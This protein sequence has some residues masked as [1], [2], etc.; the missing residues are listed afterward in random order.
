[1]GLNANMRIRELLRVAGYARVSTDKEEQLTSYAAQLD[2]YMKKIA[3]NP[4]WELVEVYADEGLSGTSLKKRDNFNR[5]I[6]DALA[7]KID[8]III[9]AVITKG[10]FFK[11]SKHRS[12]HLIF[13]LRLT[14][15]LSAD[16]FCP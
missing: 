15:W 9:N 16:G 8:M 1:M 5:M 7:G 11:C 6:A 12:E 4:D 3:E 2:Y 10:Q 14:E 13:E